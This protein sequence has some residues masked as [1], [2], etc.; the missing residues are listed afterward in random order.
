MSIKD[1]FG[2]NKKAQTR[3]IEMFEDLLKE[4]NLP[5][6]ALTKN[7]AIEVSKKWLSNFAFKTKAITGK[8]RLGEN[9][10]EAFARNLQPSLTNTKALMAYKQQSIEPFYIFD[11][12][13]KH[14]YYCEASVFPEL[15]NT[16]FD[17]YIMPISE[18]WTIVFCH[19]NVVYFADRKD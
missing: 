3:N 14:C 11:E 9:L 17:I 16:G 8:W 4:Y 13:G 6:V 2:I 19:D 1:L 12:S 5:G 15:Y 18:K 7:Q 10:W